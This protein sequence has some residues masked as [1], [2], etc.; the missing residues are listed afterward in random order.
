MTLVERRWREHVVATELETYSEVSKSMQEEI[1]ECRNRISAIEK[2]L[3]DEPSEWMQ[4]ALEGQAA[5]LED[6]QVFF[7]LFQEFET[8]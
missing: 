5:V 3:N 1:E 7:P 4:L 6:L 8:R 2:H